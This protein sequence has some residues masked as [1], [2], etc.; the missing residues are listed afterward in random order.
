[1]DLYTVTLESKDAHRLQFSTKAT[2]VID[3]EFKAFKYIE[4][5][6]WT[7][8]QYK[9]KEIIA[10]QIKDEDESSLHIRFTS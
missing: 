2:C 10:E 8:Y 9:V 5:K 4:E 3:A 6:G 1:M 7:N